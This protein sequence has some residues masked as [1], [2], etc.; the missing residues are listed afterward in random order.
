MRICVRPVVLLSVGHPLD[1]CSAPRKWAFERG[2]SD[3]LRWRCNK[4]TTGGRWCCGTPLKGSPEWERALGLHCNAQA[5]R[6]VGF[7]EQNG[8]V[9]R[10]CFGGPHRLKGWWGRWGALGVHRGH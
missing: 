2:L 1:N 6:R 5:L 4:V 10:M 7:P 9:Q 3:C 8:G